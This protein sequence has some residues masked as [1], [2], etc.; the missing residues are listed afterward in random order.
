MQN[1]KVIFWD[2]FCPPILIISTTIPGQKCINFRP[3]FSTVKW[4]IFRAS[5]GFSPWN[6]TRVLPWTCW[7]APSA[8]RPAEGLPA[9]P[10]P[11][12]YLQRPTVIAY[13]LRHNI[14]QH[15]VRPLGL[16]HFSTQKIPHPLCLSKK[17]ILLCRRKKK[18]IAPKN[19]EKKILASVK[20]YS[21]PPSPP[22]IKWLVPNEK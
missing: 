9:P 21:P 4:S 22:R 13:C 11:Q 16:K 3:I 20:S 6:H 17:K 19:L 10:D 1:I 18:I 12:L 8:P 2:I 7:R 15:L 5:G 14:W